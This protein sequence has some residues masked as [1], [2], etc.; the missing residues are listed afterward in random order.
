MFDSCQPHIV[1]DGLVLFVD[2][3][4]LL[5]IFIDHFDLFAEL[6]ESLLFFERNLF[7]TIFPYLFDVLL[8]LVLQDFDSF[9]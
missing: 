3:V 5:L 1:F 9:S 8:S 7:E 6:A 2:F 4:K